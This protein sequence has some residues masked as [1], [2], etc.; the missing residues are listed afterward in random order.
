MLFNSLAYAVFSGIVRIGP[1]LW[2]AAWVRYM[3]LLVATI[4]FGVYFN[5]G[6][7]IYFQF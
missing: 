5:A 7:F 6:T 2:G 3:A 4:L 1:S